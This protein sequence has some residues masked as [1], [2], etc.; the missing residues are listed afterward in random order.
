[1]GQRQANDGEYERG[2]RGDLGDAILEA[3]RLSCRELRRR[4][5]DR[6]RRPAAKTATKKNIDD[7]VLGELDKMVGALEEAILGEGA[8]AAYAAKA[9]GGTVVSS[10]NTFSPVTPPNVN[11][12]A[13]ACQ[14]GTLVHRSGTGAKGPWQAWMCGLPKER[15]A[16]QCEP[17]WLRKGQPGW[18]N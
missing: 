18:V 16:E 8:H 3:V 10:S 1:V 12:P 2:G 15:K 14:H 17:Q 13:P 6:Q 5:E 4:Q 9:L 7:A 11:A